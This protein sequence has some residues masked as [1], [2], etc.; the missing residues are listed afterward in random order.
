MR[1]LRS[2][3]VFG[4]LSVPA[5]IVAADAPRAVSRTGWWSAMTERTFSDTLAF[6]KETMARVH[7]A[8]RLATELGR[9]AEKRGSSTEVRQFGRLLAADRQLQDTQ[10]LDYAFR[11]MGVV[12]ESPSVVEAERELARQRRERLDGLRTLVGP[13][14]DVE[15][16]ALASDDN[17]SDIE[18][19]DYARTQLAD[20]ALRIM[21]DNTM[22]ILQQHQRV[23][24][25]LRGGA[26]RAGEGR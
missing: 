7:D 22:P 13:A 4:V 14:F 16:L 21:L 3:V 1:N 12:L 26:A 19:F 20:P 9:L 10:V 11:R 24:Q 17:Q 5:W 6:S 18:L 2:V 15:L 8:N 23:V 25:V